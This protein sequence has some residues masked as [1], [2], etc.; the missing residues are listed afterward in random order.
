[1]NTLIDEIA[2]A[3]IESLRAAISGDDNRMKRAIVRS[4]ALQGI[5]T[6]IFVMPQYNAIALKYR[7]LCQSAL[8]VLESES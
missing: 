7:E 6:T 4:L 2:Q 3:S 1:M 8:E 5:A